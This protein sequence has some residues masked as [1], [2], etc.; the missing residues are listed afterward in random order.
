MDAA[1]EAIGIGLGQ[2]HGLV[3]N[4]G[5]TAG[6]IGADDAL[7]KP[8]EGEPIEN[9]II[10]ARRGRWHGREVRCSANGGDT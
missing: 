3:R 5:A 8:V 1:R 10:V 4:L 7:G 2:G 9:Q 6:G